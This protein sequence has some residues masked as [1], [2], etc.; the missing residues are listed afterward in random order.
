ME[1]TINLLQILDA[2]Q[3]GSAGDKRIKYAADVDLEEIIIL[4]KSY[5]NILNIFKKKFKKAKKQDNIWITDFKCGIDQNNVPYRWDY[6]SIMKG[7][8][9]INQEKIYFIDQLNKHSIIKLDVVALIN[10][11]LTEFSNNY[12]FIIGD[13]TTQ[14]EKFTPVEKSLLLDAVKYQQD[15]LYFKSLKRIFAFYKLIDNIPEQKKLITL[16]NS[17]IGSIYQITNLLSTIQLVLN[18]KFKPIPKKIIIKNLNFAKKELPN[19]Y[20]YLIDEIIVQPK[21]KMFSYI[22][23]A[24]RVINDNVNEMLFK[25]IKK[26]KINLSPINIYNKY[27]KS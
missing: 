4:E 17:D 9:T 5:E 11:R 21:N 13:K 16:F 10:D 12:Y 14:P 2:N 3:I 24:K 18:Q 19:E 15:N 22:D 26:H 27:V 7:Y 6:D 1:R 8:Q 23:H 20:Q 25:Y